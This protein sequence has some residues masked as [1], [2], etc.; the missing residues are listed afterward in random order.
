MNASAFT[1]ACALAFLPA[2]LAHA[3]NVETKRALPR[4]ET[5]SL[6]DA[7]MTYEIYETSIEHADLPG[8]PEGIDTGRHFCRLT[9][10]AERAHVFV[11]SLD[12]DQPL[13]AVHS[14]DLDAGLPGF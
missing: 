12:G 9:L 8:C 6:D 3:S 10:A 13:V 1:L 11:F 2:G 7:R 4:V 5:V 14:Y